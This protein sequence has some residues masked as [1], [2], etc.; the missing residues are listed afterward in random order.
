MSIFLKE[1]RDQS[2][3]GALVLAWAFLF[4]FGGI[5]GGL[6]AGFTIGVIIE[7]KEDNTMLTWSGVLESSLK[8]KLDISFYTLFG[9]IAGIL[10][11][12]L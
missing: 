7:A 8:S 3:H 6:V 12:L 11:S 10:I 2:A 9:L 4:A 1:L 5:L